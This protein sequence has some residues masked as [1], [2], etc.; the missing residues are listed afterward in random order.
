MARL[1]EVQTIGVY[2]GVSDAGFTPCANTAEKRVCIFARGI[3]KKNQGIVYMTPKLRCD[4]SDDLVEKNKAKTCGLC[5]LSLT[6]DQL[7]EAAIK[8]LSFRPPPELQPV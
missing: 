2:T 6:M 1:L 4:R 8:A 3:V 5:E 7:A